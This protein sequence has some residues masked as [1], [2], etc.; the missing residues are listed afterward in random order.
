MSLMP[1][2]L[3]SVSFKSSMVNGTPGGLSMIISPVPPYISG[4]L[5]CTSFDFNSRSF[6][7][8]VS[9]VALNSDPKTSFIQSRYS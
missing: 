6:A 1:L 7:S 3:S 2:V 9:S 4:F 5:S 8:L